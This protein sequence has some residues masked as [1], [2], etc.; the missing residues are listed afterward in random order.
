[1]QHDELIGLVQARAGL[2]DRGAAERAAPR[3]YEPAYALPMVG[4]E[5][6][7]QRAREAIERAARG[8]GQIVGITAEAGMGK[9]RLNAVIVQLAVER[10]FTGYAG[11]GQSYGTNISYLAWHAIWRD[12]FDIAGSGSPEAQ[13]HRLAAPLRDAL[14]AQYPVAVAATQSQIGSGALP[15]AT[16]PSSAF[17]IERG[18]GARSLDRLDAALRALPCAV[19]G[20][21][22]SKTLW[23]DLRCLDEADEAQFVAQLAQLQA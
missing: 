1:M 12:F 17:A 3:L 14:G 20:R 16:L 6:E 15:V 5:P 4:R 8:Q 23:L 7:L 22:A 21:I 2:P 11:A 9:S 10:G 18:R 19:I 13:A